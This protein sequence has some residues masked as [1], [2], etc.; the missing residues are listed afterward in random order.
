MH[1]RKNVTPKP[2]RLLMELPRDCAHV[3]TITIS[4]S[5]P[6]A[7]VVALM[8]GML[9]P[10]RV[11]HNRMNKFQNMFGSTHGLACRTVW[12]ASWCW[13]STQASIAFAHASN[14]STRHSAQVQ[15]KIYSILMCCCSRWLSIDVHCELTCRG[16]DHRMRLL[17]VVTMHSR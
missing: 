17:R 2:L 10:L 7:Q 6:R 15:Y 16:V 5:Q 13:P 9:T 11:D 1:L 14:I 3:Q 12:L 8:T 4:C